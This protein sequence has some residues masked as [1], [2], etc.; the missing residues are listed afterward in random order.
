MSPEKISEQLR[1]TFG[2]AITSSSADSSHPHVTVT[3]ETKAA[4]EAAN[5]VNNADRI[6]RQMRDLER[7]A[8]K[9][10]QQGYGLLHNFTQGCYNSSHHSAAC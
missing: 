8:R 5:E 6:E 10:R 3:A 7:Q 4:L 1:G 9:A 2:D